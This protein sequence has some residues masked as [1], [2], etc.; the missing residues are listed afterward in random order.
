MRFVTSWETETV[1]KNLREFEGKSLLRPS[2]LIERKEVTVTDHVGREIKAG[3]SILY[4]VRRG[5][6]MWLSTMTVQQVVPGDEQKPAYVSGFN[7]DGRRVSVHNL[8]NVVVIV[9]LGEQYETA[10]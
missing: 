1:W 4:P 10:A 6:D 3:C 8:K 5:S 7:T 2:S 9:P